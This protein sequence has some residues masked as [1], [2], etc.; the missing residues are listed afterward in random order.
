MDKRKHSI[1]RKELLLCAAI[2]LS[3]KIGYQN[4]TRIKIAK[5]AHVSVSLINRYFGKIEDLKKEIL[6]AA[7]EKEVIEI[8]A[9]GLKTKD[10]AVLKISDRLKK[11][12]LSFLAN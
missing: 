3:L 12:A 7:I 9:Q 2:D 10:L 4:I 1:V 11:K 8:I 5:K 6:K